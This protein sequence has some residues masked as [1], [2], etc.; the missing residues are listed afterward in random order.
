V[1]AWTPRR[2][3]QAQ[4]VDAA[5]NR[6]EHR[7]KQPG[8]VAR[9]GEEEAGRP[10][11]RRVV[12]TRLRVFARSAAGRSLAGLR[13]SARVERRRPQLRR[14]DER[15]LDIRLETPHADPPR[16]LDPGRVPAAA[17]L[18]PQHG[19]QRLR[20]HPGERARAERRAQLRAGRA[21]ALEPQ[22]RL[23]LAR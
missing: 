16:V 2:W 9:A 19:D 23:G 15:A 7:A 3:C 17:A 21:R 18:D 22:Q 20:L 13:E 5:L 4:S 12:R 8:D 14:R 10:L 11:R 6:G 1:P